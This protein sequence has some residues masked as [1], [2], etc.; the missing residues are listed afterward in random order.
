[1]NVCE[2]A[3]AILTS[4][5]GQGQVPQYKEHEGCRDEF[6]RGLGHRLLVN[7]GC[8]MLS[9]YDVITQL[10]CIEIVLYSKDVTLVS[11]P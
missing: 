5:M 7:Y 6:V 10:F 2:L 3:L 8:W 11:V 1:M 9:S 4:P